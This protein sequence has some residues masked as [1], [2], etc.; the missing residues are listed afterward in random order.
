MKR[1]VIIAM[2]ILFGLI[3]YFV[4]RTAA[5]GDDATAAE[6]SGTQTVLEL[7][8]K[9]SETRPRAVVQTVIAEPHPVV[10]TLKGRTAPNRMVT[11]RAA[12]TGSVIAAP[13]LEGQ[14]VRKGTLLCRLDVD[15]RQA[16]IAEAQAQLDASQGDFESAR[17]LVEKGWAAPS[18]ADTAKASRDAAQA[19]LDAAK[20]EL[21]RTRITAPFSGIFETRM[22]ETGDFLSPSSPCGVIADLNPIRVVAEVTEEYAS[23]LTLDAPVRANILSSGSVQGSLNYVART[24]DENTRTFKIEATIDNT[25]G[26]ISAGLTSDL[27]IELGETNATKVSPAMLTLHDDGRLGIRH[28]TADNV[29]RFSE[30]SIIDDAADGVW[31]TGLPDQATVISVGQDY[32]IDGVEVEP[33]SAEGGPQ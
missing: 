29:V 17:T 24:A 32:L 7:E 4:I 12:T 6:A 5:R 20:I 16:R 19:S 15:A 33:V 2:V 21:G 23:A 10:L 22:A 1:S 11:V 30:V 28:I 25:D 31:I 8:A 9:Q 26:R 18:R 13:D 3:A 27:Q 14:F